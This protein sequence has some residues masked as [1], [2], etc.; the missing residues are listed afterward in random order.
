LK[1]SALLTER[2]KTFGHL[3]TGCPYENLNKFE[4]KTY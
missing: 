2:E 3:P 4:K 1:L